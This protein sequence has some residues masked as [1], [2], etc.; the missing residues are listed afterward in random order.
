MAFV[1][2]LDG[3]AASGKST[4]GQAVADQLGYVYFDTGLLYRALTW[5][6]L[7]RGVAPTDEQR[8]TE[9]VREIELQVSESPRRAIILAA[10]QELTGDGRLHTPEVDAA[11]SVVA[12]HPS[13]RASL[14]PAQR[15]AIA[16]PGAVL[17]GRDIGTVIVPEAPLKIWLNASAEERARRRANQ[18]GEAYPAVLEKMVRRDQVDGSRAVAP[19][20]RAP[21]AVDLETDGLSAEAVTRRIVALARQRQ[22]ET[23]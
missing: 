21:D 13:V 17:A 6:A 7:Q 14:K 19:M 23:A 18:T 1:I 12:A 9:L 4:V 2:A 16:P 20:V 3:P 11:I 5:L 22:A 8:L 15:R 10:S